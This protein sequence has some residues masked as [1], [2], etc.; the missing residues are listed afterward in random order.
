MFTNIGKPY[1]CLCQALFSAHF[2]LLTLL[3]FHAEA[4]EA[5][6][7]QYVY[8]ASSQRNLRTIKPSNKKYR[9]IK[10]SPLIFATPDLPLASCFLINWDDSWANLFIEEE[11]I[12]FVTN[13]LLRL[14]EAD[15]GGVIYI[16]KSDNF[17][18][19][20]PAIG[21][22]D[23]EWVSEFETPVIAE[24]AEA[25]G[26]GAMKKYG[27]HFY[28]VDDKTFYLINLTKNITK[29]KEILMSFK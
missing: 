17:R 14:T 16:L 26:I 21:L 28:V 22:G 11:E 2:L 4:I 25:S 12:F 9:D 19:T 3:I 5:W 29:K 27:I 18:K 23:Y 8:H 7:V 15:K 20:I 24:I 13:N 6:P 1:A 10:E